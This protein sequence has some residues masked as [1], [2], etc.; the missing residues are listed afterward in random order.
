M[1]G[2]S[3]RKCRGGIETQR[4]I[5]EV[6]RR[7]ITAMVDDVVRESAQRLAALPEPSLA[8]VR[9]AKDAVIALSPQRSAEMEGLKDYLFANVY[10]HARI[11]RIMADAELIV[12]DL[13]RALHGRAG[14]DAGALAGRR[15]R[16]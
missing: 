1:P 12:R 14:R 2:R 10:R 5:Y 7:I 3:C 15:G 6:N 4:V 11:T 9:A 16:R 8:G 13:F